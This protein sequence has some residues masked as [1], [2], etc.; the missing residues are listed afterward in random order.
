MNKKLYN[1]T[2]YNSSLSKEYKM[3]PGEQIDVEG[4]NIL[5]YSI[6]NKYGSSSL[7][8]SMFGKE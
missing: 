2:L 5:N 4:H 3:K 8:W 6:F 7:Y 1:Q